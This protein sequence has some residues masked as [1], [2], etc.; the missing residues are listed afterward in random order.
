MYL[1]STMSCTQAARFVHPRLF[2]VYPPAE[3]V[4]PGSAPMPL[5]LTGTSVQTSAVYLLDDG[6]AL[7]LWLGKD[8]PTD[9]MQ[10]AFGWA[11]PLDGVDPA[12]LRVLPPESSAVAG[13]LH[14]IVEDLRAQTRWT[15]MPLRVV[16]QG[17]DGEFSR[18]LV[19]DQTKQMMSYPEFMVHCH[20]YI[21]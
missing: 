17:A 4:A 9:F 14:A 6:V 3:P 19:E 21:L 2:Q 12:T 7:R 15:W 13:Q 5:P 10:A 1:I 18:A 20:R 8:T 16:K 11:G